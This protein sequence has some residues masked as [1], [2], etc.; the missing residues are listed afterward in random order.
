MWFLL[1]AALL[2]VVL[3]IVVALLRRIV[4]RKSTWNAT[5]LVVALL[6]IGQYWVL[7][8]KGNTFVPYTAQA[9]RGFRSVLLQSVASPT[10]AFSLPGITGITQTVTVS[11]VDTPVYDLQGRRVWNLESG[12]IYVRNGEKFIQQ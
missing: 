10:R 11:P 9:V 7:P 5:L 1:G 8:L 3:L 4:R 2:V 12:Q 6:A